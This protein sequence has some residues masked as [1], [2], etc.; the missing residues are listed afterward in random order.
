MQQVQ[1]SAAYA[2]RYAAAANL[3][4]PPSSHKH[5]AATGRLFIYEICLPEMPAAAAAA[6]AAAHNHHVT[7]SRHSINAIGPRPTAAAAAPA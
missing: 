6:A 7:H 1:A 2:Q 4:A 3:D 5:S